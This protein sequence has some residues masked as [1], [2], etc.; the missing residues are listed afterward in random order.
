MNI[1]S[2]RCRV[3]RGLKAIAHSVDINQQRDQCRGEV[4]QAVLEM[5]QRDLRRHGLRILLGRHG[6]TRRGLEC[7]QRHCLRRKKRSNKCCLSKEFGDLA[8]KAPPTWTPFPSRS[9][10][11]SHVLGYFP[12]LP[13]LSSVLG[14]DEGP[15]RSFL[16]AAKPTLWRSPIK[17]CMWRCSPKRETTRWFSC[18]RGRSSATA[19]ALQPAPAHSI[20]ASRSH[21]SICIAS[22]LPSAHRL[23]LSHKILHNGAAR[24][25]GPRQ[26]REAAA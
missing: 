11:S 4:D 5:S 24:V 19:V 26:L 10:G 2:I 14:S 1:K 22:Q 17:L 15:V 12:V 8:P 16:L 9:R 13:Q 18:S 25:Q 20:C 6:V 7:S 21:L 3:K 23:C